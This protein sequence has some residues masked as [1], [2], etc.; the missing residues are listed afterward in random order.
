MSAV[1]STVRGGPGSFVWTR[2]LPREH[3]AWSMLFLPFV[4]AAALL[5]LAAGPLFAALVLV[6]A[7]FLLRAPLIVLA[8]QKWVWRDLREETAPARSATLLLAVIASFAGITILLELPRAVWPVAAACG[9][10]ASGL[11]IISI[12]LAVRNKHHSVLFQA[13]GSVGLAASSL[14]VAL[15]AGRPIPLAI[16]IVWAG[17]ALHGVAAIPIV[18]ARLALRRRQTPNLPR[19]G[20]GIAATAAAAAGTVLAGAEYQGVTTAL[21]FSALAHSGEWLALRSPRTFRLTRLGFRL[22]ATSL[23]FTLILYFG[24][25]ALP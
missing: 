4:A 5:R 21:I 12:W 8:R 2:L 23:L 1:R 18:H 24:A 16:W 7:L 19:A 13:I 6:L 20:A 17:S 22:M 15:A 14:T 25:A 10:A 3:G 9:A 11:M